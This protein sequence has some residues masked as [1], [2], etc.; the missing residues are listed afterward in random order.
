MLQNNGNCDGWMNLVN[1]YLDTDPLEHT[2]HCLGFR[3]RP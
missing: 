1:S 3:Q 2:G